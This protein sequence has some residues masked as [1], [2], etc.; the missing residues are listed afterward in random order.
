MPTGGAADQAAAFRKGLAEID[1]V[2]GRTIAVEYRW[3]NNDGDRVT[4]LLGDLIRR[5]VN[6]LAAMGSTL[7]AVTAKAI[8]TTV[9]IVFLTAADP[10]RLG[11][12]SSLNRPGGN[13]TGINVLSAEL[14]AKGL[15]LMHELLPA[16][17][18]FAL[19]VPPFDN[20]VGRLWRRRSRPL[21]LRLGAI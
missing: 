13:V 5:R 8:T 9:P 6:V 16:A 19:L 3:G 15:A 1:F 18:R 11:L 10:V 7:A 2:E 12:V 4:E 17:M 21:P 14:G 20:P